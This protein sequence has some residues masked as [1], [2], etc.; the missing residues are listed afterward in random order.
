MFFWYFYHRE[1]VFPGT[2]S[3][4]ERVFLSP[5]AT[6]NRHAV[7]GNGRSFFN[8]AMRAHPVSFTTGNEI[9]AGFSD[10]IHRHVHDSP[11]R[12]DSNSWT[13][14]HGITSTK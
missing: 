8:P 11:V 12:R 9:H 13:G 4:D 10:R 2:V 6:D 5:A 14:R 1:M 7:V 3:V